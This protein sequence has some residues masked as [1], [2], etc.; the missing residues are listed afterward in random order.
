MGVTAQAADQLLCAS[1]DPIAALRVVGAQHAEFARAQS[2]RADAAVLAKIPETLPTIVA[3]LDT[4][5]ARAL[6]GRDRGHLEAAAAWLRGNAQEAGE[7]YAAVALQ[8]PQD[9]VA[10]RLAQ[11][12]WFFVGDHARSREL[13]DRVMR[14]W[15]RRHPRY[16]LVLALAAFAHAEAGDAEYAESLGRAALARDPACPMGVHAVAHA[17][18]ESDRHR[19]GAQWMRAQ[20]AQ[21]AVRSRMLT[22]NAWHLAMFDVDDGNIESA[23]NILDR[24]LLPAAERWPLDGCDAATLLLRVGR[25]GVDVASRWARLSDAFARTWHGGYWPFVDLHAGLVHW[26]AGREERA[27]QLLRHVEQRAGSGDFSGRRAAAISAPGL[28]ALALWARGE[29][30]AAAERLAALRPLLRQAGGSSLQLQAL[31][32]GAADPA[33]PVISLCS[34]RTGVPRRNAAECA[35]LPG[36][37]IPRNPWPR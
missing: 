24:T 20:R 22:H 6:R 18:G 4:L 28:Q 8:W 27:Q 5:D 11:S 13:V 25:E 19:R 35:P 36:A 33:A 3:A 30:R 16:R 7:R 29:Q 15:N 34:P 21:W 37:P 23:I 12:C 9:L 32:A 1:G 31:G 14:A 26:S 17:V 10:L 2:L